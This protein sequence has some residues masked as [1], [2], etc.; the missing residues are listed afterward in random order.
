MR[1]EARGKKGIKSICDSVVAA[2]F[3]K[4]K[5][6]SIIWAQAAQRFIKKMNP[7]IPT[8]RHIVIKMAR[9]GVF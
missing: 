7:N 8:P 5:E 1:R 3:P 6:G 4:L 2:R 9:A